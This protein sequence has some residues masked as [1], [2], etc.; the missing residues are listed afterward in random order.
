[1][2]CTLQVED[3]QNGGEHAE[4]GLQAT[5]VEAKPSA[6]NVQDNKQK[7]DKK[8]A[9]AESSAASVQEHKQNEDKKE[10]ASAAEPTADASVQ[11]PRARE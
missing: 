1:M 7:A 2:S 3:K 11:R 10:P 5:Q 9:S 8:G 6:E 4:A